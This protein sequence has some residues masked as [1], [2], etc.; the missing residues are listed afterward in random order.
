MA[1][2]LSASTAAVGLTPAANAALG[3]TV[4]AHIAHMREVLQIRDDR[5]LS[6]K[7]NKIVLDS[8]KTP[9]FEIHP[10]RTEF[11]Y[12]SKI[13]IENMFKD[14]TT[15][16]YLQSSVYQ[17]VRPTYLLPIASTQINTTALI[18][19]TCFGVGL[20]SFTT[21]RALYLFQRE[22]FKCWQNQYDGV[23]IDG[24]ASFSE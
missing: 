21:L 24:T 9:V 2:F 17:V 22:E 8:V 6:S 11:T 5:I 23:R 20:I 3:G 16:R 13:I 10:Y 19:W 12:N 4:S 1:A 15:R 7:V 14:H 18:S